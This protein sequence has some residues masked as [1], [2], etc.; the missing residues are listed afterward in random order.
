MSGK[1]SEEVTKMILEQK[2][3]S[4][5]FEKMLEDL[6]ESEREE[7]KGLQKEFREKQLPSLSV[8]PTSKSDKKIKKS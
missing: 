2:K 6:S 4:G 3:R 7:I 1:T 5:E 8:V